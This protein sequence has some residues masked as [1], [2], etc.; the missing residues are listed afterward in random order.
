MTGNKYVNG[1]YMTKIKGKYGD[2]FI[3]EFTDEGIQNLH[4]LNRN[5]KER[6]QI[7]CWPRKNSETQYNVERSKPRSSS[8]SQGND[9]PPPS[10][11]PVNS[12]E[13]PF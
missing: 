10:E 11:E 8:Q 6:R 12:D 13:L 9:A 1:I 7:V 5:D 3:I 4:L 2:G